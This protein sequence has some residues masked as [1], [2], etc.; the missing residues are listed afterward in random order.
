MLTDK[1]TIVFTFASQAA[2][3]GLVIGSQGNLSMRFR[4][5]S[6]VELVAITPSGINY[7]YL[8]V[9]DI[10]IINMEGSLLE[11][12]NKVSIEKGMH[13]SVYAQRQDIHAIVHFHSIFT[14]VLAIAGMGIPPL[15]DEQVFY[16]GGKIGVASHAMPGSEKLAGNV[17]Q[18]L[19]SN[20]A[21]IMANHGA[22]T[23][24]EDMG[25]A[26]FN[27][28]LLD[29]LAQA[30]VYAKLLKKTKRLSGTAVEE[31]LREHQLGELKI[32][33]S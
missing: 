2:E 5:E 12:K 4:D 30:Y 19:G 9:E 24:G 32:R 11:G 33:R 18:A 16:L 6:G 15:L 7:N 27:A 17:V 23:T 21:V 20:N 28:Q 29:R 14:S 13:L 25:R 31:E 8:Q 3:A 22:L 1:K 26:F 10:V